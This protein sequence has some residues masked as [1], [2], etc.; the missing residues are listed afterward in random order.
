MSRLLGTFSLILLTATTVTQAQDITITNQQG[1]ALKASL[2]Q[3]KQASNKAVLMLHQCNKDRTMYNEIGG[4]LSARGV[5]AL[6][7]DF[8]GYGQSINAEFDRK[9]LQ[10]L[11]RK[12]RRAAFAVIRETWPKD[13]QLAYNILR[14]KVGKQ[15]V[16]GV[17]G[18]SCGG[19][20]AKIISK[21]NPIKAMSFFSS[22]L[23]NGD[24]AIEYYKKNLTL[25]PT[26]FIAAEQ[27]V[28]FG[29]TQTGFNLN[30]N[31]NSQ[32]ISYKGKHHGLPLLSQDKQLATTIA[33]WFKSNLNN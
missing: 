8:R 33:A 30:K 18:A 5:Y 32:F 10:K 26:L 11:A 21:N 13:T 9:N 23:T 1:F 7:F 29:F 12:D 14:N 27:D 25:M 24:E 4:E 15:G 22:A 3:P 19:K 31:L 6:S 2:Y 17:I 20:Q 28:T 16:I